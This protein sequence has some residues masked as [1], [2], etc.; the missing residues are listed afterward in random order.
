LEFK[1]FQQGDVQKLKT[2][3]REAGEARSG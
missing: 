1:K 3:L 2:L